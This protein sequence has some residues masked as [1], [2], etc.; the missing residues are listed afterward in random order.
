MPC[1]GRG[2]QIVD[3]VATVIEANCSHRVIS[4]GELKLFVLEGMVKFPFALKRSQ[5][6]YGRNFYG[7]SN[8]IFLLIDH[9]SVRSALLI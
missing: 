2:F 7:G 6:F 9:S 1:A 3:D 5:A 4:S 8:R